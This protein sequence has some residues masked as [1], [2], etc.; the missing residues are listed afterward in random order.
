VPPRNRAAEMIDGFRDRRKD[1][2]YRNGWGDGRFGLME[3]FL[4]NPNLARWEGHL[5]GC[6]TTGATARGGGFA[7]S[8]RA[9][10]PPDSGLP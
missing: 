4:E 3:T 10:T 1:P 7:R 8:W 9:R 6:R 5:R 2:A